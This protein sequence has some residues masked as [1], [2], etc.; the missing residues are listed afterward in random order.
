M[1]EPRSEVVKVKIYDREYT[2]RTSGDPEQ[3]HRL[4]LLLD[5]R[6]REIAESTGAV[7]TLKVAILAALS[8]ADDAQRV[9]DEIQKLDESLSR[10]SLECVSLL[11]RFLQ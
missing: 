3:L 7:D 10:R 5:R 6:M 4:C 8:L 1:V 9:A 11:D 2:L